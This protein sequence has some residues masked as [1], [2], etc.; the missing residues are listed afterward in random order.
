MF[1]KLKSVF[2]AKIETVSTN[3]NTLQI[4]ISC[5]MIQTAVHDGQFDEVEKNKILELL[6][7]Y[8]KLDN[9]EIDN[10]FITSMK[11]NDDS[12]DIHQFTRLLNENLSEEEKLKIIEMM[13]QII[14]ADNHID[15]YENN[16]IRKIS[17]L[18]Y[19]K[20]QDVGNIKKKLTD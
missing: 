16:L 4:A 8:F 15:D 3:F 11:A 10:L 9:N 18:L 17:G 2:E 13:W 6:K 19:L 1:K 12:N 20:D 5:L 14:I 7:D